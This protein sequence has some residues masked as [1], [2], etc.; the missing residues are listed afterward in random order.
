MI[1]NETLISYIK[2]AMP[3]AVVDIVDRTGTMDHFRI[4]I[5][6]SAFDGKNLLDRQRFVYQTLGEPMQDGRIHALE[7]KSATPGEAGQKSSSN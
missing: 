2:K 4:S 5:V 3:D 7:I 6:S 1:S